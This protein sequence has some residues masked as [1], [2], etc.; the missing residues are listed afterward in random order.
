[1]ELKYKYEG[2]ETPNERLRNKLQPIFLLVESL[3]K[4]GR[5]DIPKL[6]E[7]C[8]SNLDEIR[9][10]LDDME[11]FYKNMYNQNNTFER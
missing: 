9:D 1:M 6:V 5:T 4:V 3:K 8:N 11:P 7:I 10:H 2:E